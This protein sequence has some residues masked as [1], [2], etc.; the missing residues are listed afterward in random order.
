[1][2]YMFCF[3][4]KFK[5]LKNVLEHVFV[6]V[7]KS[8]KISYTLQLY[9]AFCQKSISFLSFAVEKH[10]KTDVFD[11]GVNKMMYIFEIN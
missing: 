9:S 5:L 4:V 8:T 2:L 7:D 3:N 1:M 6:S 10:K 11:A